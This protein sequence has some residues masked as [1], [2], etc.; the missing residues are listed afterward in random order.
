MSTSS[1]LIAQV[2][3][4][5]RSPVEVSV[6]QF[7]GRWYVLHTK[8]RN[9]KALSTELS[10]HRIQHFLPLVRKRRLYAGRV[11]TVELPLFAGYLFLCGERE[12]RDFAVR[13]NRVANVLETPDQDRLRGELQQIQR[14]VTGHEGVEMYPG[15]VQGSRCRVIAGSLAGVEGVVLRR[16]GPWKVYLGVEMLGQ[17]AELEIDPALLELLD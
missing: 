17:S 16:R 3:D 10:R 8:A 14:V 6:D 4:Y 13:T 9:E 2:A 5:E 11:R 12:E 1:A 7:D 15:L